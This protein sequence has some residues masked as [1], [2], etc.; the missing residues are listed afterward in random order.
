MLGALSGCTPAL[1]SVQAPARCAGA[2]PTAA[3]PAKP[4]LPQVSAHS[5][6]CPYA[7][8]LDA[9]DYA[10]LLE[11]LRLLEEDDN[12][13]RA[14]CSTQLAAGARALTDGAPPTTAAEP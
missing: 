1:V 6:D 3:L 9:A 2:P 12:R 11:R 10:R 5:A 7:L 8:C 4:Y 14:L 13:V